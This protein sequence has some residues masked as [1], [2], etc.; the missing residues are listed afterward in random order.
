LN[1][2]KHIADYYS[3]FSKEYIFIIA[4]SICSLIGLILEMTSLAV[5]PIGIIIS[6]IVIL[7]MKLGYYLTAFL[8]PFS[9]NLNYDSL[10]ITLNTPLEPLL[11]I[12]VL[13]TVYRI[14]IDG[15][16]VAYIIH[17]LSILFF[18]FIGLL[19][20]SS[21]FST[22][23]LVSL[24]MSLQT[25]AYLIPA[26]WGV[27]YLSKNDN[28]FLRKL[29]L[30]PLFSFSIICFINLYRHGQYNFARSFS[31]Y[32]ANPFYSDH[33]IYATMAALMIPIAFVCMLWYFRKSSTRFFY[34][35]LLFL[36][37]TSGLIFSYSRAAML[38]VLIA[39]CLF[40]YIRLKISWWVLAAVFVLALVISIANQD[41]L[42]MSIKRNQT[43]SKTFKTDITQQVKS[44]TNVRNDVSNLERI[45]RWNSALR[46]IKERP[47]LGFGYG[48]YQYEYFPYQKPNET[49]QISIR[50]PQ[51]SYHAGT[52]GTAHSEYL[53]L[54][55]E[56]GLFLG[57][58]YIVLLII[59]I[60]FSIKNISVLAP[61]SFAYY[62]SIGIAM[63]MTTYIV[64][65]FF[66][67]FLD[68][69]KISF[70]F[71]AFLASITS[72]TIKQTNHKSADIISI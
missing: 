24:R 64:H 47:F 11:L 60:V 62:L 2:K 51:Y 33:T 6:L 66:N 67:N 40:F 31:W 36:L 42:L 20:L 41:T 37:C 8:L 10:G 70:I 48:T 32:I 5:L 23:L 28:T 44:I 45:N 61:D 38:S 30:L 15:L 63:S 13:T 58:T 54:S 17:P 25:I 49:T 9:I 22:H 65:G 19:L 16:P 18:I 29:F 57:L 59:A 56:N 14:S 69:P 3:A 12:L 46:M 71:F 43:E 39:F 26:Y 4:L 52:G 34:F 50:N 68:T 27:L 21:F 53:L 55:S 35:M 7:N 1:F 72:I